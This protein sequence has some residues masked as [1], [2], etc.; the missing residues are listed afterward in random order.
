[1]NQRNGRPF[2][3]GQNKPTLTNKVK[4]V[5]SNTG[6]KIKNA[7][8]KISNT[9]Q[10][11][12]NTIKEKVGNIQQK[13]KETT[14]KIDSKIPVSKF[15]SMTQ[16]F[17]SANTAISKFVS[18]ILALLLFVIVFQFG[19]GILQYYIGPSYNP[20]IINGM[21]PSDSQ[22]VISANPNV[23]KSVPIYR[24]VNAPQGLEFSWN[25]WFIIQ[26]TST[27]TGNSL[28]FSKG[29]NSA[30]TNMLSSNVTSDY[31][32]VAPGLFITPSGSQNNLTLVMNT[33]D[34][35]SNDTVYN[36]T[37]TITDIPMQK[38]VSCTIR[39]QGT[40]VDVYINGVLNQRKILMNLP[41]QNYYDTYIGQP[42]GFK[43]YVSSLRYYG[44]AIN[45]DEIQTL[46]AAG[47][48]LKMI[49][50]STMPVTSDYISM[51]WYYKYLS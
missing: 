42:G 27:I 35:S 15:T 11:A 1:M 8:N 23:V 13:V 14:N 21:V 36:E 16:D 26:D 17:L 32:N 18:F 12:T 49:S 28:I 41:K 31:L 34:S 50:S 7:T 9:A 29:T 30:K 2:N 4:E 51:N 43:G 10:A 38:W 37:I 25:V 22:T 6:E 40:Y 39:V 3:L 24:S 45:Y 33:Y 19:V 5:V 46:F 20:Y 48:S 47:P 44:Y